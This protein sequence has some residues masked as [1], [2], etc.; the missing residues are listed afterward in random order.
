[1]CQPQRM[2][3]LTVNHTHKQIR[4][5]FKRPSLRETISQLLQDPIR[6]KASFGKQKMKMNSSPKAVWIRVNSAPHLT[7][8]SSKSAQVTVEPKGSARDRGTREGGGVGRAYHAH[9]DSSLTAV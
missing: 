8:S 2:S 5:L 1:M 4:T 7:P 9:S 3:S 6:F